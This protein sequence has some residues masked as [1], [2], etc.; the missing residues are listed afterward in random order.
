MSTYEEVVTHAKLRF[1]RLPGVT[2]D[3]ALIT[4]DNGFDHT[5]PNTFGEQGLRSLDAALDEAFAHDGVAA[6]CLTGK[7]FIFAVGADLTGVPR[8]TTRDEALLIGSEG[9][10]V[11]RRLHDSAVPTFALVN[12]AA[13]GGGLEVA[14][15]CHYRAISSGAAAVALPEC[16]LGLIPGWGGTQL[17]PRLIGADKALQVTVD[18]AL[19]QNKMLKGPQAFKLG[20]ADVMFEPADFL[21]RSL[22]WVASVLRGETIVE[23]APVDTGEAWTAAVER[24]RAGLDA[25]LHGAAPAPYRAV[26]LV[27]LA[28]TVSLDEGFAAEDEAL[29]DL[30]F[31]DELRS[32][33]YAFDLTQKRAKRP[34]GAPKEGA[35]PVT[36]VGVVGA[37]LMASQLG[38]LFV[39]RLEVPVVLTDVDQARIDKGVGWIHE[40][41]DGL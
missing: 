7:P 21:E 32:G 11:F 34:V 20:I 10:R 16:F 19:A 28:R 23:R 29:A 6:V 26:A 24:T 14:L 3:I 39:Q 22:E 27:E 1:V 17:L 9:H 12:G 40:Q 8:I 35:R 38:L 33:L 13:L 36:K 30:I 18:N 37:G 15:H 2:G 5:K 4:L 41:I 31:S 25:K